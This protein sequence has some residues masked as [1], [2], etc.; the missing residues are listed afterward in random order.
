MYRIIL[1]YKNGLKFLSNSKELL[2]PLYGEEIP[3]F[4]IT[5]TNKK[6]WLD[7]R[8]K[9]SGCLIYREV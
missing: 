4:L 8:K 3:T 5:S 7:T 1:I 2:E 6:L 9:I